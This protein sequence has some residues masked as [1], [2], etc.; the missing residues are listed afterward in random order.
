MLCVGMSLHL[1]LYDFVYIC[2]CV[3]LFMIRLSLLHQCL[4]VSISN[5][6]K[7]VFIIACI[8][9]FVNVYKCIC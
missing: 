8:N 9:F 6:A 7:H 4:C 3:S 5:V 2:I 1:M